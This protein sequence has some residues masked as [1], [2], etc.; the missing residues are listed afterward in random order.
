MFD[1]SPLIVAIDYETCHLDDSVMRGTGVYGDSAAHLLP[2]IPST[3]T[4]FQRS[5][6]WVERRTKSGKN[7]KSGNSS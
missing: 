4:Y 6:T 7:A 2:G 3:R 5:K 1:R